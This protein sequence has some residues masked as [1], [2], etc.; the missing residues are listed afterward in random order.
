MVFFF[1]F[2]HLYQK[3]PLRFF[4]LKKSFKK[5]S[6]CLQKMP[7]NWII[8][9]MQHWKMHHFEWEIHTVTAPWG[10]MLWRSVISWS[11]DT[12]RCQGNNSIRCVGG[13]RQDNLPKLLRDYCK[14]LSEQRS[15]A[16]CSEISWRLQPGTYHHAEEWRASPA[17]FNDKDQTVT[18]ILLE[19]ASL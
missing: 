14:V 1:H 6:L 15:L 10:K 4:F 13:W 7:F 9:F 2:I 11:T 8:L 16:N 17:L 3:I 18:E 19:Q 12:Q 5:R